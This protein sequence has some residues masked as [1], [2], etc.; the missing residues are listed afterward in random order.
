MKRNPQHKA[1][2]FFFHSI[3]CDMHTNK[4]KGFTLI[5]LLVVIAIIGILS[6]VVLASLNS[7]RSKGN[8]AAVKS[9]L[10]T[11]RTQANLYL[12]STGNG[13]YYSTGTPASD[14]GSVDACAIANTMFTEDANIAAAISAADKASGGLGGATPTNVK[15]ANDGAG[16]DR[17]S[18]WAVWAPTTNPA[19]TWWCIDSSGNSKEVTIEPSSTSC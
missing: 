12:D 15:C 14:N 7:A 9:N 10:D 4:N 11:V 6:A 1:V 8:A 2:D 13:S 3:I 5:E 17:I 19:T 16:T 18:L